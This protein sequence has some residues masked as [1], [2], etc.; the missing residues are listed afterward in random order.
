MATQATAKAMVSS[1]P[2]MLAFAAAAAGV[3]AAV[4]MAGKGIR[5]IADGFSGLSVAQMIGVSVALGLIG[6]GL[7]YITPAIIAAAGA[8]SLSAPGLALLALA[9]MAVG[10]A[11]AIAA[12]GMGVMFESISKITPD[13]GLGI[14]MVSAALGVL[15]GVL[16]AM[17]ASAILGVIGLGVMMPLLWGMGELMERMTSPERVDGLKAFST[18]MTTLGQTDLKTV[19]DELERIAKVIADISSTT[20]MITAVAGP[21]ALETIM[22]AGA[23]STQVAAETTPVQSTAGSRAEDVNQVKQ[24]AAPAQESGRSSAND[25]ELIKAL[26]TVADALKDFKDRPVRLQMS[27]AGQDE[28]IAEIKNELER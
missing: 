24:S 26:K 28:F 4:W 11:V 17:G 8:A 6:V 15:A 12:A 2:V 27:G 14:L 23:K 20:L 1:I 13:T 18:L 3:G 7:Y 9:V 25:K 21:S 22:N 5:E 16:V 10:A 19:A